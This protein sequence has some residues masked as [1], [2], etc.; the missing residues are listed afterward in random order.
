MGFASS[1]RGIMGGG[2]ALNTIEFIT[3]MTTGN[4]TVFYPDSCEEIDPVS[5]PCYLLGHQLCKEPKIE[6]VNIC[7]LSFKREIA[8]RRDL[9]ADKWHPAR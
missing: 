9:A 2:R 3:I 4:A 5:H 6:K 1:T 8:S 7:H